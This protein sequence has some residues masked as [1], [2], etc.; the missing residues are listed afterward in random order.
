ME[1]KTILVN[2]KI[3][4]KLDNGKTF[5][6]VDKVFYN[7]T[8][9]LKPELAKLKKDEEVTLE[10]IK[11]GVVNTVTK[12]IKGTTEVKPKPETE[13]KKED[14]TSPTEFKCIDC[15]AD[16]KD[17]KYKQCWKCSQKGSLTKD[18]Q[19]QRGNAL[20]SAGSALRGNFEGTNT[21]PQQIAE[22]IK[23]IAEQ[24]LDWLKIE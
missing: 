6:L 24:L 8:D 19:I 9:S 15:G 7:V 14:E 21:S 10:V 5:Q 20:N 17:G 13:S 4:A 22:A 3:L 1:E 11:K 2:G 18:I 16:L 23:Y 12:I